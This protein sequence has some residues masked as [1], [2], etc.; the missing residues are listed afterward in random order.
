MECSNRKT[1]SFLFRVLILLYLFVYLALGFYTELKLISI[2]PLPDTLMQD[3]NYYE[4]GLLDA[5]QIN[6]PYRLLEIGRGYLYPPPALFIVEAFGLIKSLFLKT[7]LYWALNIG[8]LGLM[9]Y[10]I[11]KRY[12][13]QTDQ[14]WYWYVICLGFAPFLE[15]LHIGQ[16]NVI[17]LFGIFLLFIG[18]ERFFLGSLGLSLAI[19][20][21]VSPVFFFVYLMANKKW[22][23]VAV[24]IVMM[25]IV[26]GLSVLRYGILSVINYP[27]VLLWLANQ[28]PMG[29]NS[30]SLVAKIV[31]LR[32]L[33]ARTF[34]LQVPILNFV[35]NNYQLAHRILT[36][37]ILVLI[38]ISGLFFLLNRQK[39]EPLFI[40]TAL[41]MT[42]SSNVM[43]Y[44]HYVF[45][46]LPIL[47]WMGWS[48][49][50]L[51]VIA[52]CLIGLLIVQID[53]FLLTYGSLIHL[54]GH[55]SILIIL[56]QQLRDFLGQIKL[57]PTCAST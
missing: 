23:V 25:T 2:K 6:N 11:A 8:L 27:S 48:R 4:R 37:Y 38:A 12:G 17:T 1:D 55:I 31:G 49:L 28:F 5:L 20:T 35:A 13:Y 18:T 30:Q 10:G 15:L 9:T 39:R 33:M 51:R 46:L 43:W 52:W 7:S 22:R 3:F 34:G 41:G 53:R 56:F 32:N 19:L 42:L 50:D 36:L 16:I 21:K 54:F 57:R 45:Y 44:H 29:T 40:I 24:S 26:I 47:I 14:I